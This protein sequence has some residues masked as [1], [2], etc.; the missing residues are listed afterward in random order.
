MQIYRTLE[1]LQ[2]P[3]STWDDFLVFITTQRLNS[4]SVKA[5]EHHLGSSKEPPKWSQFSEFLVTRLLSL[6]AFEKSRSGKGNSQTH[7]SGVKSFYQGKSNETAITKVTVCPL[8]SSKHYIATCPQYTTKTIQQKL[9]LIAKHKL[10]YNCLG[11][12][13]VSGCR[14]TKRCFK[15]GR[16]HHT[17]IHQNQSQTTQSN[18]APV[19]LTSKVAESTFKEFEAQVLHSHTVSSCILLATIQ[20]TIIAPNG[21]KSNARVLLDQGSEISLISENLVQL[22]R[23]KRTYSSISESEENDRISQRV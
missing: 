11:S 14:T 6:Q 21:N 8:C 19:S 5:W 7:S 22:L 4:E 17:T 15:C 10:C 1:T 12:H 9:A 16:R 2:R 18:T 20:V 3:V 23:L 13:R